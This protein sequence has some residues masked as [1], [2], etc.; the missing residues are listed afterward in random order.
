MD[1]YQPIKRLVECCVWSVAFSPDSQF[2]GSGGYD[3]TVWVWNTTTGTGT[4]LVQQEG[5]LEYS[6]V[7]SPDGQQ[8]AWGGFPGDIF[9]WDIRKN[10]PIQETLS[11]HLSP[12]WQ[13]VYSPDQKHLASASSDGTVIIW[14]LAKLQ[15]IVQLT[16]GRE[17]VNGVVFSPDGKTLAAGS[18]DH[19]GSLRVCDEGKIIVWEFD[20][21]A[22]QILACQISGR[23]LSQREWKDH[24]ENLPYHITCPQW[25]V[26]E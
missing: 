14:D 26:G 11:E 21:A 6:V 16:A 13:V 25:P 24:F 1:T 7:F 18:C 2:L 20:P 8:L 4:R 10:V 17:A 3:G 19:H 22:W 5:H 12:V 23:N 15:P 9:L